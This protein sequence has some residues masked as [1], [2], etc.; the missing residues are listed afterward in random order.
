MD[1]LGNIVLKFIRDNHLIENGDKIVVGFSGGADSVALL[2][3]L[4]ELRPLLRIEL[5]AVHVN[6]GLRGQ[7]AVDDSNFCRKY[8]KSLSVSFELASVDTL[9]LIKNSGMTEEEAAR[10]L[11]YAAIN[12]IG[13]KVFGRKFK[14]AVAHQAND[15]AETILFNLLRGSGL[16]GCSGMR[17][18]REN[19]IRPLLNTSRRDIETWLNIKGI[20][21]VIDSTNQENTH[22]RNILRNEILPKIETKINSMALSHIGKFG[23]KAFEMDEF[24]SHEATRFLDDNGCILTQMEDGCNCIKLSKRR[25]KEKARIFRIYV[26]IKALKALGTPMKDLGERHFDSIDRLLFLGK[27]AHTD[28]KEALSAENTHG[29]TWL[30]RKDRE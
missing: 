13:S 18:K 16:K 26:I 19:I 22:S 25:L 21:Y 20:A 29:E 17:P 24:M 12:E 30:I 14:I 7:E 23:Q 8:S 5:L 4:S 2:T 10:N 1:K 27:G 11:R 15:Q 9:E 6:H 3:I 28:L